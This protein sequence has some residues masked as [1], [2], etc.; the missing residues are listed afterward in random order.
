MEN[1]IW[2][3]IFN[4]EG[5]YEVSNLGRVKSL[6]RLCNHSFGNHKKIVNEKILSQ[7]LNQH[8]YFKVRLSKFGIKRTHLIHHLVAES[9]LNH[10]KRSNYICV[11]HIDENPKNNNIKNLQIISKRENTKKSY[12][13]KNK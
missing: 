7:S 10:T 2:K 1:E 4:Y 6:K 9:F 11:D 3:P 12:D 8:G 13:F 5:F